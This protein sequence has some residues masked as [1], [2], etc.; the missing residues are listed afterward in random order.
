MKVLAILQNQWFHNPDNVRAILKRHPEYRPRIIHYALFAGCRTG[1]ILKAALRDWCDRIIWEE[2][3]P[4]IGG[5]ASACFPADVVHLRALLETHKPGVV[6]ALGKIAADALR[7]LV[8]AE[9]L[10]IGPHPAARGIDP[11]PDLLSIR[12]KLEKWK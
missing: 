10:L 11:I 12:R 1:R 6:I 9:Q 7:P 8:V 5:H 4:K 2:A 3:S